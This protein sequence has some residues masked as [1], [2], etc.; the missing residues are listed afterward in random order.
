[1][2]LHCP[3]RESSAFINRRASRPL[4]SANACTPLIKNAPTPLN[5]PESLKF[6]LVGTLIMLP[7]ITGYA[8]YAYRVF[9]GKARELTYY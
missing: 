6:I 7:A 3:K 8:I 9:H 5:S 1:M 2:I 4:P